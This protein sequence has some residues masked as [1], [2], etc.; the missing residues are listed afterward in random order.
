MCGAICRR[1]LPAEIAHTVLQP[2]TFG[3][4]CSG[5]PECWYRWRRKHRQFQ[6]QWPE[7]PRIVMSEP[8]RLGAERDLY[9]DTWVR[10]LGERRVIG[11]ATLLQ[12]RGAGV[13]RC[14]SG[15]LEEAGEYFNSH[16][17]WSG[18]WA[19]RGL[20][21]CPRSHD[22]V[23]FSSALR[24]SAGQPCRKKTPTG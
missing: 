8:Q 2:R 19:Q 21:T 1:S 15:G 3:G 20:G 22:T 18:D 4:S 12:G 6:S 16:S 13:P 24:V 5:R 11:V 17:S 9:R 10:Y 14:H 7:P 23:G